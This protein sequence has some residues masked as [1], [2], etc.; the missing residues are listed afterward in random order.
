MI[1]SGMLKEGSSYHGALLAE[2]WGDE[3]GIEPGDA[4]LV[5]LEED[6]GGG[7]V[8]LAEVERLHFNKAQLQAFQGHGERAIAWSADRLGEGTEEV[9]NFIGSGRRVTR[10]PIRADVAVSPPG[11]IGGRLNVPGCWRGEVVVEEGSLEPR[12][13][14]LSEARYPGC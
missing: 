4:A 5:I 14:E 12:N 2:Y 3:V 10:S 6:K 11:E 13:A 8:Y 7:A 9:C 1:T